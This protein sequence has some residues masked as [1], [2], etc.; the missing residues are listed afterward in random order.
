[1]A[2]WSNPEANPSDPEWGLYFI[3]VHGDGNWEAEELLSGTREQVLDKYDKTREDGF[4]DDKTLVVIDPLG[5][6]HYA[7]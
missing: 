1:M 6:P 4:P 3:P 2:V 5:R 7:A